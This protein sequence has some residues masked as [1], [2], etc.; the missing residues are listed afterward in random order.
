MSKDLAKIST[1][2]ILLLWCFFWMPKL[3][4]AS[5]MYADSIAPNCKT[6]KDL[7]MEERSLLQ[8]KFTQYKSLYAS[9]KFTDALLLW[10]EIFI[11]APG[12]NG[13]S[14]VYF[15]DGVNIYAHLL[16]QST[17]P[18]IQKRMAD[19]IKIIHTKRQECMGS[20]GA[21]IGQIAFDYYFHLKGLVTEDE[22]YSLFKKSTDMNNGTMDYFI[23]N[24]FV[25]MIRARLSSSKENAQEAAKYATQAY[26]SMKNGLKN[27]ADKTCESWEK[28]EE[29]TP[30]L[31][32]ELE[33]N[34]SFYSC[35]Y[36]IAKYYDEYK[37][38]PTDCATTKMV[39]QKLTTACDVKDARYLEV[40]IAA[41]NC[42]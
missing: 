10:R 42:P 40:K 6:F 39:L 4:F 14:K 25:S 11:K 37:A 12:N 2:R 17:D 19:T 21:Y 23:I 7:S 8:E 22:T 18:S 13:R 36:F 32:A 20:D 9:Q 31:L 1:M 35:D 15:S 33:A 24:P 29:Y 41:K 26:I 30:K 3:A 34:P 28:V 5:L 27:C 16:K 38:N